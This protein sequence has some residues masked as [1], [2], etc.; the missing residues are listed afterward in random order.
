MRIGGRQIKVIATPATALRRGVMVPE[1]P[2][3]GDPQGKR[4]F[5]CIYRAPRRILLVLSERC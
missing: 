1:Y 3:A 2:P 4:L 5:D